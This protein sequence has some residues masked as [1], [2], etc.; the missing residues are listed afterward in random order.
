MFHRPSTGRPPGRRTH[1]AQRACFGLPESPH[2]MKPGIK[3]WSG[4]V[5]SVLYPGKAALILVSW[6]FGVYN[7]RN[8]WRGVATSA[9]IT[10]LFFSA[11]PQYTGRLP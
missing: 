7:N 11:I 5:A 4:N 2:D 10:V 9:T 1:A 8:H 3:K 6:C